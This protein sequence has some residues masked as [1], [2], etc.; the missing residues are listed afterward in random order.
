MKRNSTWWLVI[1]GLVLMVIGVVDPMEGSVVILAGSVLA[2]AGAFRSRRTRH[3]LPV[4]AMLLVAIGVGALF[5]MS[6][7]GGVGG[8]T[9][10]SIWWLLL[11]L[12][13][14]VGWILGLIG[15]ARTLRNGTEEARF[16]KTRPLS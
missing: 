13:Y 14:P 15:A 6:A 5:G 8:G 4:A 10:R 7:L 9:G 11:C 1:A 3:R 12:P 16:Q 2:A